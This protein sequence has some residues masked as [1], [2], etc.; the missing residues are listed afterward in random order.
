MNRPDP[1]QARRQYWD[2][3]ASSFDNEPDHGLKDPQVH[4]AWVELLERWLPP[5]RANILDIGCGTGSL[6]VVMA[7]LG[8]TVTGIDISPAMIAAATAKAQAQGYAITFQV[9]E[10]EAPQFPP[11]AF[12]ALVCR[13]VLWSLPQPAQVLAHWARLLRPG[14]RMLLI[15]GYWHT[16]AG[17]HAAQAVAALPASARL[18]AVQDLSHQPVY[19]G[20]PVTD[21]RY[22]L[23]AD[24]Y[25]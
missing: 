7:G 6:S 24:I 8:H 16:N 14:G 17:M 25:E 9:M 21:E 5:A 10:A 1:E 3:A 15:E 4:K 20:G 11:E 13:H 2:E 12:D 22:I 18:A 19:W 23:V